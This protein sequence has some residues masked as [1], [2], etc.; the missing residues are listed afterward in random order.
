MNPPSSVQDAVDEL[1]RDPLPHIV[2]LK[3][4]LAYP[5]HVKVHRIS[6]ST[7]A[8][9]LVLLDTSVSPYDRE[10]YPTAAVAAFI[11]SDHPTLTASLMSH[12]P[13]GVGV[14][15]KLSRSHDLAPVEAQFAVGRRTAF[16][17]F[18]TTG[19]FEQDAD[20]RI[21]SE[22]GDAALQLFEAQGHER[23][24]L[25]PLLRS[26]RAF[27]CVLERGGETLSA[28]IAFENYA[29]VWEVG[30]VITAPSYRG[31]GFAARVVR[32]ALAKLSERAL[33][34]RYQ[35]EEHNTASIGLAASVG[36]APFLTIVH[37][38]HE[39]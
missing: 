9:T 39:C 18:T 32:T 3:Q 19:P 15:F 11:A 25:K 37:Y 26:D 33:I 14:V 12:V 7:G 24:W 4:L 31:K 27:A 21:T 13:R 8:A 17:S 2:L 29:P 28:C 6:D 36:L 1:A 10:A 22:P 20:V 23:A 38:T 5:E 16:V 35:V 30:G 34:P